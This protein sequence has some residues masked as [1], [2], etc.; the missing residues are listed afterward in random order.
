M[1]RTAMSGMNDEQVRDRSVNLIQL[2]LQQPAVNHSSSMK[3]GQVPLL[4]QSGHEEMK[5]LLEL[6]QRRLEHS[7]IDE[8]HSPPPSEL[9]QD[10][11]VKQYQRPAS[12]DF[13]F[14]NSYFI[15]QS[16]YFNE[17]TS[18]EINSRT[19]ETSNSLPPSTLVPE[20]RIS[21]APE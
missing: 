6:D 21:D 8:P 4:I 11:S 13:S 10:H 17:S 19:N 3:I 2:L 20:E 16:S 1:R 7:T 18:V 9:L 12:A 15:Q 5:L 14:F